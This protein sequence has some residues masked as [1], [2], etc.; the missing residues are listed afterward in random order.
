[1]PLK[2][3][4]KD[5]SSDSPSPSAPQQE[6][7]SAPSVP[8]PQPDGINPL[9]I[10]SREQLAPYLLTSVRT[11]DRLESLMIGPPR[12]KILGTV[13]YRL[14]SVRKWLEE[15]E[16]RPHR[17]RKPYLPRKKKVEAAGAVEAVAPAVATMK[18]KETS[19]GK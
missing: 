13:Y 2:L 14:S 17:Q 4:L 7:H 11:L 15:Q 16:K 1:M 18:G 19:E 3:L 9:D 10:V 6:P 8:V 12:I 5:P